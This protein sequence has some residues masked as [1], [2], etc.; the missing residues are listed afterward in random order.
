MGGGGR[1]GVE[2][3]SGDGGGGRGGDGGGS[4]ASHLQ[5]K[6]GLIQKHLVQH[7]CVLVDGA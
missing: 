2:G 6:V 5:L 1:G 4:S 3:G 7:H